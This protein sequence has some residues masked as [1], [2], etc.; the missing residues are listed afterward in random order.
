MYPST[1]L[2]I[3]YTPTSTKYRMLPIEREDDC[4]EAVAELKSA[5]SHCE[6][7]SYSFLGLSVKV[8][9]QLHE[10]PPNDFM[11]AGSIIFSPVFNK[12]LCKHYLHVAPGDVEATFI[13][14]SVRMVAVTSDVLLQK[15]KYVVKQI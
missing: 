2:V 6:P 11:V 10:V 12:W 14:D 15:D 9:N 13:D 3:Y 8:N 7:P 1:L 5:Y 4:V